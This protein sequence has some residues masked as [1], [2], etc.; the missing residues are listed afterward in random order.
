VQALVN[1]VVLAVDRQH[2]DPLAF[3]RGHHHGAGHDQDLLVGQRDGL[4]G[5]DRRENRVERRGARRRKQHDVS[6]WVRGDVDQ[7]C[8]AAFGRERGAGW[9]VLPDLLVQPLAIVPRGERDHAQFVGMGVND[10]QRALTDGT[11]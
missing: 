1:R 11:G 6:L 5:G 4:A 3:C 9:P 8:R 10:G 7:A 2:R